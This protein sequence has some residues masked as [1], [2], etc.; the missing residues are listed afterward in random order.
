[1]EVFVSLSSYTP[2]NLTAHQFR[3]LPKRE[4]R[5]VREMLIKDIRCPVGSIKLEPD[6]MKLCA[7][8][9]VDNSPID[10]RLLLAEGS[11]GWILK[12]RNIQTGELKTVDIGHKYEPKKLQQMLML[13]KPV[14]DPKRR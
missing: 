13:L 12:Q 1:M 14:E 9:E 8:I 6:D 4:R 11:R 7:R 5:R 2:G 10:C 3:A